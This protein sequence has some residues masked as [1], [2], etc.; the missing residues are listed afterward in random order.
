ML[1][2]CT[3]SNQRYLHFGPRFGRAC[4]TLIVKNHISSRL[5]IDSLL[6]KHPIWD[7]YMTYHGGLVW[8]TIL[9]KISIVLI[10]NEDLKIWW[11]FLIIIV[12]CRC[13]CLSITR[14]SR[15]GGLFQKWPLKLS[16]ADSMLLRTC[17]AYDICHMA[18]AFDNSKYF[19]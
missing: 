18:C 2:V 12:R 14:I 13:S 17:Y 8:L 9:S 4:K 19:F 7:R 11:S 5:N 6:W 16:F 15:F 3:P 1:V 10:D